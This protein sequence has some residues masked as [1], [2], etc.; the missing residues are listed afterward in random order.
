MYSTKESVLKFDFY[1]R[2]MYEVNICVLELSKY[3]TL[4]KNPRLY[5]KQMMPVFHKLLHPLSG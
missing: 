1:V 4:E 3:A 5:E 2:I